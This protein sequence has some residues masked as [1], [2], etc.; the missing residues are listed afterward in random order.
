MN[1]KIAQAKAWIAENSNMAVPMG[2]ACLAG[3]ILGAILL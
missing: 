2:L 1:E 3:F